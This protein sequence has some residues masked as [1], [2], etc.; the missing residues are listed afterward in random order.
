MVYLRPVFPHGLCYGAVH[1]LNRNKYIQM[2]IFSGLI[3]TLVTSNDA[4][5]VLLADKK[6]FF[7]LCFMRWLVL[8]QQLLLNLSLSKIYLSV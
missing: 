8:S 3:C 7:F 5:E 4:T 6:T 1:V 2:T